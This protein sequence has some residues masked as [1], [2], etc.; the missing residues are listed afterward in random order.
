M[1]KFVFGAP[2]GVRVKS[3]FQR[4]ITGSGGD[5]V[6]GNKYSILK[7]E[8]TTTTLFRAQCFPTALWAFLQFLPPPQVGRRNEDCL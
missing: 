2:S 1:V 8:P 6:P 5:A 4:V 7:T 3:K